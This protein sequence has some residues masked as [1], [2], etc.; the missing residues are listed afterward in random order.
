MKKL[1]VLL[2]LAGACGTTAAGPTD[3]PTLVVVNGWT[4]AGAQWGIQLADCGSCLL[5]SG[6]VAP[7][8]QAC[9]KLSASIV[10]VVVWG[11]ADGGNLVYLSA[12]FVTPAGTHWAW[13]IGAP[14][15]SAGPP[16]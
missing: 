5:Q 16:C 1:L 12:P 10:P 8:G 3:E 9:V 14:A 6:T 15:I 11:I 4:G 13:P 2:A 7:G